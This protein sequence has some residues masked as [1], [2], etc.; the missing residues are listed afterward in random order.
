MK[1]EL[2][3][4]ALNML[5]D[6]HISDTASFDPEVIQETPER[7]VHMKK[8]R[9]ISLVLA[10]ALMLALGTAAYAIYNW[11]LN[12][13]LQDL[14]LHGNTE[15]ETVITESQS[16]DPLPA[17]VD[18]LNETVTTESQS[19]D[20]LPADVDTLSL[21]GYAGSPEYKAMLE[22]SEFEK[23]YDRDGEILKAVGNNP[24]P[25]NNPAY[26]VYS[27]EMADTLDAIA[28][29]Y[30]L[31]L[32]S[33]FSS[34]TIGELRDRFGDFAAQTIGGYGYYYSDGTFQCDCNSGEVM[35]Q[36]R[37]NMKG[38]LDTV[39]LN[40][41]NT[42]NYEQWEY[43]TACGSTVL[44]ALAPRHAMIAAESEQSFTVVN[45]PSAITAAE[46][47]ALADSIDFSIL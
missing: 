45:V 10:A 40:V 22:W 35:F 12:W 34:T 13:Q 9:I 15:N 33:G 21:Q 6:R 11:Q 18:T 47:E 43:T 37:R 25:W 29:K 7:I 8:K 27:Q 32:H 3:S 26:F 1:R 36:I 39:S 23:N 19:Y 2:I 14:V 16:Y 28:T 44:L 24:T 17:D 30:G 38:V 20:P 4:Q 31:I 41:S 5:D 42:K 46:L